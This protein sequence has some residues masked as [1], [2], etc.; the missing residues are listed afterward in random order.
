MARRLILDTGVLIGF[1]RRTIE[2]ASILQPDDD[3]AISA[4]T[5]SELLMGV[6]LA[7]SDKRPGREAVVRAARELCVVEN[8]TDATSEY[9]AELQV[10]CR[11]IG[12]P[13]GE[14][15][16]IIAATSLA[17]SRVVVT[18]DKRAGFGSLPG[19]VAIEL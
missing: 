5:L 3:V 1:E 19:V 10:H 18:L 14:L 16:L 6:K 11:K 7:D 13:R 4:V 15:D 2:P 9:H 17:T 8:F 12:K